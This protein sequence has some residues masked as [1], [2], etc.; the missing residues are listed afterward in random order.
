[1]NINIDIEL[2]E[3]I[4]TKPNEYHKVFLYILECFKNKILKNK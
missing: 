3:D 1:M 2:I 4:L